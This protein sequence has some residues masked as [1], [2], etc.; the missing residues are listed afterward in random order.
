M[1][2]IRADHA[3]GRY[4][5]KHDELLIHS[6][7]YRHQADN[8]SDC[9]KKLHQAIVQAAALPGETSTAQRDRVSR[10]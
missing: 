7:T 6:D 9:L 10:L 1:S 5:T 8:A 3:I 2:K 4:M